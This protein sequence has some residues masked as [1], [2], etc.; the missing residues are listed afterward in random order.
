M[1]LLSSEKSA[2]VSIIPLDGLEE[3]RVTLTVK[4]KVLRKARRERAITVQPNP[5]ATPVR[6]SSDD[7]HPQRH[8]TA[9]PKNS[10]CPFVSKSTEKANK[11]FSAIQDYYPRLADTSCT[12]QFCQ[13][14]RMIHTTEPRIGWD[15]P[16][17]D[18]KEE[19]EDFLK[20][21]R[22]DGIIE[23]D[24]ELRLRRRE[25]LQG[26]SNG[27]WD[28][29][30]SE[31]E[32]GIRLAWKHSKR[33]IMR[34]EWKNLS[35]CD[36]RHIT[37]SHEMG[38]TLVEKA[39]EA[40]NG[41]D[42]KPTV[43]AF[44][45]G[46][47][48]K[49]GSRIW[50]HQLLGFAGYRQADGGIFG[51]PSNADVTQAIIDLGWKPPA[52]RTKWDLLPLVTQAQDDV[53][54]ITPVDEKDFPLVYIRH[55]H[56]PLAFDRLGLRWVAAPA[57][58]RFGFDIGGVQ[59]TAAPFMGWFMDAEIGLRNLVDENRYNALPSIVDALGLI[60]TSG[61]TLDELP[62]YERLA[63]LSRA[64]TELNYAVYW[65]FNQAGVRISDSL[66]ASSM[67]CNFDDE[68]LR[69]HGFRLPADPYWLSPPGG[70]IVPVWHRG[71][72]PNYQP[73][74]LIA[75]QVQDPVNVWRRAKGLGP[76]S[77]S[78]KEH[79][80]PMETDESKR[81][82]RIVYC[83]SGVIAFKLAKSVHTLLHSVAAQP[84]HDYHV[85]PV[86][87][88]NDLDITKLRQGDV[89]LIVASSSGRGHVPSNGRVFIRKLQDNKLP[90]PLDFKYTIFGNGTN[91]IESALASTGGRPL[92]PL[93]KSDVDTES[94][95]WSQLQAWIQQ[96]RETIFNGLAAGKCDDCKVKLAPP[97]IDVKAKT[98]QTLS[99][100]C[101]PARIVSCTGTKQGI[102][103]VV[104][105][106]GDGAYPDMCHID[107][108]VPNKVDQVD[109]MLE[110]LPIEKF[111]CCVPDH[112]TLEHFL[113]NFMDIDRPFT[114]MNWTASLQLSSDLGHQIASRP[115]NAAFEI[116][117]TGWQQA[118]AVADIISAMPL[119]PPRHYSVASSRAYLA[120]N[121][122]GQS[123]EL[124]VQT[125]KDGLFSD[126][127]LSSEDAVSRTLQVRFKQR[128]LQDILFDVEPAAPIIAFVTGSGMAPLRGYLQAR[129]HSL[130]QQ[131]LAAPS[132]AP[133]TVLAAF[134]DYDTAVIKPILD[135]AKDLGIIDKLLLK[136]FSNESG[137]VSSQGKRYVQDD[138][139][140]SSAR[141]AI[142][143]RLKDPKTKIFVCAN[144]KAA[145][146]F[147]ENLTALL[148]ADVRER[149][150][151][152]YIEEVFDAAG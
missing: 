138:I 104:L 42:I 22:R 18:V 24:E 105:D 141:R 20:Q 60:R 64:Q 38:I 51:D 128:P 48:G 116:P 66:T 112:M 74:P 129:I 33:C 120:S 61:K 69:E 40:F 130:Q 89:V 2:C 126:R 71:G 81:T 80:K 26:L 127:F 3:A 82:I 132:G 135:Q 41:G 11:E 115:V 113:T 25:A 92:L 95:P 65:S 35:L 103:H 1:S 14:G 76:V 67:Y 97:P 121:D 147:H 151:E 118:V 102:K 149:F 57:L 107:V 52:I 62:E 123:V 124:L 7:F 54:A 100:E 144:P 96:L 53:P 32:H 39:K 78:Q 5:S 73:K 125:Q 143:S 152:R 93:F 108:F 45:P 134:K 10:A 19:A 72:A 86:A 50:N 91:C 88:L 148:G 150:G 46:S 37:T 12:P 94:P 30:F 140:K 79:L 21:L 75:R 28:L 145:K 114:D 44:P 99:R 56:Y 4:R 136:P 109:R 85:P 70:S 133:V 59:Y 146:S 110:Q 49:T 47:H 137:P 27:S 131:D 31:I 119:R 6:H 101:L 13:G 9:F 16:L 90:R 29:T 106:V 63:C 36:L 8:P 83:S 68:H 98:I 58:S 43:F 139:F 122:N 87:T 84:G 15:K 142:L 17:G 117:L 34:S 111:E 23:S 55:P 77:Y